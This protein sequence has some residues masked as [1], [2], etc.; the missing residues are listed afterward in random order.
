MGRRSMNPNKKYIKW[1]VIAFLVWYVI[2][3]PTAAGQNF[4]QI[5]SGLG[6]AGKSLATFVNT[7]SS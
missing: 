1:A 4:Q 2:N 3:N 6:E 7:A 5:L